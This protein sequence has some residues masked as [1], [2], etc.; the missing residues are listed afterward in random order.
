MLL[1]LLIG[2][3]GYAQ[4]NGAINLADPTRPHLIEHQL[5][6]VDFSQRDSYRLLGEGWRRRWWDLMTGEHVHEGMQPEL[7]W[8][9]SS[10]ADL[11]V[12]V[13]ERRDAVLH[14]TLAQYGPALEQFPPQRIDV[15][16]NG[17]RIGRLFFTRDDNQTPKTFTLLVPSWVQTEGKNCITF[18][19]RSVPSAEQLKGR[20]DIDGDPI[21]F[22]LQSL[23]F[24]AVADMVV[25]K[26]PAP[27]EAPS[28][29]GDT[30]T[31]PAFTRVR[32][33]VDLRQ[34][35]PATLRFDSQS[36]PNG[37]R[38]YALTD[39]D[40]SV[41]RLSFDLTR[42]R[43]TGRVL[44]ELT[45]SIAEF[46]FE[47][48][49]EPVTW[50]ASLSWSIGSPAPAHPAT[51]APHA[52]TPKAENVVFVLLD[53]L[54]ADSLGSYGY[55]RDTAPTLDTMARQGVRLD[56]AYAPAPYTYSSTWSLLTGRY[57]HQHQAYI[58]PW[59]PNEAMTLL[60]TVLNDA[61]I[62]TALVSANPWF[63][64]S[65][66]AEPF[67]TYDGRY[68][69]HAGS[70]RL[71]RDPSEVT[72]AGIAYLEA[73]RDSRFFLYLHF[74]HPH[75]PYNPNANA[76][77]LTIDAD[78]TPIS[79]DADGIYSAMFGERGVTAEE[80]RQLKARYDEMIRDVDSE[81][82]RLLAALAATGLDEN[83]VV[84]VSADHGEAFNEHGLLSHN[85]HVYEEFTRIPF[86]LHGKPLGDW[87]ATVRTEVYS[88]VDVFPTV[89]DLLGV[90]IPEDISGSS[91]LGPRRTAGIQAAAAATYTRNP[92]EAFWWDRYKLI[93]DGFNA[94]AQVYD[95]ARDPEERYDLAQ[96]RPVL[97][98][99]LRSRAAAWRATHPSR[100]LPPRDDIIISP[101]R[102][103]D[104]ESLGY[105]F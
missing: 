88:T 51:S 43:G 104:L 9:T 100:T 55:A 22:G 29:N 5:S 97:T 65:Q 7:L 56:R 13:L 66:F 67:D 64:D 86:I 79:T 89:C 12:T 30:F 63:A 85:S 60:P 4:E 80:V 78:R 96:R 103:E 83:T 53:A 99:F 54:R 2:S 11:H 57:P 25:N 23:R 92:I 74:M 35:F 6:A 16:W 41:V 17:T 37:A 70:E 42:E 84:I 94:F 34:E 26:S 8:A 81:M 33:P 46:V 47:S 20:S 31:V 45:D 102:V 87:A 27:L 76:N 21:A 18:Y 91:V 44:R 59:R 73:N 39:G 105:L 95:M 40:D 75:E 1:C 90:P 24:T 82:K 93:T 68:E 48:G 62:A 3:V 19:S 32:F 28:L 61:G 58:N 10:I 14:L 52:R 69:Q 101:D 77:A 36:E 49:P 50:S 38:V 72:D 15:A 71:L 98:N